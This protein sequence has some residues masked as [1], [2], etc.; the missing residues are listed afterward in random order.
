[1][2]SAYRTQ[3]KTLHA[4]DFPRHRHTHTVQKL[5]IY[6]KRKKSY[7]YKKKITNVFKIPYAIQLARSIAYGTFRAEQ[8]APDTYMQN[9]NCIKLLHSPPLGPP[10]PLPYI[11]TYKK[12]RHHHPHTMARYHLISTSNI[13][14]IHSTRALSIACEYIFS[15]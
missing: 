6:I 5:H 11:H 14:C 4:R 1:M 15:I 13:S 12:T 2:L 8:C 9:K 10:L 3:R 7:M